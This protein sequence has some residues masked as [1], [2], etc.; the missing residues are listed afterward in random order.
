MHWCGAAVVEALFGLGDAGEG[1]FA[2]GAA[3]R[4]FEGFFPAAEAG[5]DCGAVS[6]VAEVGFAQEARFGGFPGALSEA[7]VAGEAAVPAGAPL[8]R[9]GT[10][11]VLGRRY[12]CGRERR[13]GGGMPRRLGAGGGW[14]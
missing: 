7:A 13:R 9:L 6:F 5:L 4:G 14:C 3:L 2:E 11:G 10:D 12:G 8:E 1:G